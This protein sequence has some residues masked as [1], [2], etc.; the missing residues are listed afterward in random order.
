MAVN[1][2]FKKAVDDKKMRLVRI[3]LKDSMVL[4]PTFREFNALIDYAE[5]NLPA[6]YEEHDGEI[7]QS[8][9][10]AWNKDVLNG[11][12]VHVVDNFSKERLAFLRQ[13]CKHIYVQRIQAIEREITEEQRQRL[14]KRKIAT[15]M[16]VGGA[17]VAVAG[18]VAVEPIIAAAGVTIAVVG[19]VAYYK[20][21]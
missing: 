1:A 12:M 21:R 14:R 16:M 19:G 10:S 9:I 17:V 20:N 4:D 15:G 2:D 8:D 5:K 6:L 11:Q 3:M 7:F 18:A 13:I